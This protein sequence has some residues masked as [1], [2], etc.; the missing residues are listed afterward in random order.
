MTTAHSTLTAHDAAP[1]RVPA[2]AWLAGASTLAVLTLPA[3]ALAAT[4][5]ETAT[6]EN[7]PL[8]LDDVGA[9]PE[10]SDVGTQGGSIARVLIGLLVVVAVIYAVTWLLKQ[11][12]RD[13]DAPTGTGI[14]TVSST[15][16]PGGGALHLVKVGNELLLV[17]SGADGPTE[18]RRYTE[19]EAREQD[20][21]PEEPP[22]DPDGDDASGTTGGGTGG[23]V[24]SVLGRTISWARVAPG[25][26]RW[27]TALVQRLREMTVR[28]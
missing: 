1:R 8:D 14:T 24:F 23:N 4:A 16:L 28:G 7:T 11:L 5:R 20:L 22:A 6:G 2:F 27:G 21:W 9:T 18:L 3:R 25:L 17:G 13:K 10:P 12:R 19:E 15:P 26:R